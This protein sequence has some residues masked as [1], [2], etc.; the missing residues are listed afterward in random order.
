MEVVITNEQIKQSG[1]TE[2]QFKIELACRLFQLN[3][4]SARKAAEF[5]NIA[6]V[7]MLNELATRKIALNDSLEH[8]QNSIDTLRN[9]RDDSSK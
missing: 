8:F 4:F 7:Q 3:V 6:Y 5:A 2:Q 9:L 1:M